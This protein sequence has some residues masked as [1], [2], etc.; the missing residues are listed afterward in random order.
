MT[1]CLLTPLLKGSRVDGKM[2]TFAELE[3]HFTKLLWEVTR[4]PYGKV[5]VKMII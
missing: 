5:S 1:R 2:T 4:W 3:K